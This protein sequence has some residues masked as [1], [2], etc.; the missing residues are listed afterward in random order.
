M[1]NEI[2]E[3][4]KWSG[5]DAD[6]E[7]ADPHQREKDDQGE[8]PGNEREAQPLPDTRTL[9]HRFDESPIHEGQDQPNHQI[10]ADRQDDRVLRPLGERVMHE[11]PTPA[12]ED[13]A[14]RIA[15][16]FRQEI[17]SDQHDRHGE[18]SQK[19]GQHPGAQP[20][21]PWSRRR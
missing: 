11:R 4:R 21:F 16:R 17:G 10:R 8:E 13:V 3:N 14:F 1:E 2:A 19:T 5:A 12:L 7:Q 15:D 18:R 20:V 6:P 9:Q